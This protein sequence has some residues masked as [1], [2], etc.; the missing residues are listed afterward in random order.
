MPA[1]GSQ[2]LSQPS[3][4]ISAGVL[5]AV[6]WGTT[7]LRAMLLDQ[8]GRLIA[9]AESG[10]GIGTTLAGHHEE[11]LELLLMDWPPLPAILAGMAGSR[12]GWREAPYLECP[13]DADA[14][15]ANAIRFTTKH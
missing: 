13:T 6:D 5:I 8:D 14:L 3:R 7:R 11:V 9:E 4:R 15:S 2:S 1:N 12:Q 10:G